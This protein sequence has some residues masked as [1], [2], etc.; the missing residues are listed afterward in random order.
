[1]L[2]KRDTYYDTSSTKWGLAGRL[3]YRSS[4]SVNNLYVHHFWF[5][6][7]TPLKVLVNWDDYSK[8]RKNRKCS[9]PPARLCY[10]FPCVWCYGAMASLQIL[11]P[12]S[13][14]KVAIARRSCTMA[15]LSS[16]HDTQ[17]S[18]RLLR[19]NDRAIFLV[20]GHD[21]SPCYL[22]INRRCPTIPKIF[23][24]PRTE[25]LSSICGCYQ[26]LGT[27]GWCGHCIFPWLKVAPNKVHFNYSN[28][29]YKYHKP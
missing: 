28:Y 1:M 29:S 15:K 13:F 19:L 7:S 25:S 6:V 20:F 21:W 14:Q 17:E 11:L 18:K 22:D 2:S 26:L 12:S 4:I 10:K 5:V 8:I 24:L 16:A 3:E 27:F 9:K 23:R